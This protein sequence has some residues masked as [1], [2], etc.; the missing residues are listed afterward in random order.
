MAPTSSSSTNQQLR[1]KPP[2]TQL[3]NLLKTQ[4]FYWFLGHVFA[5]LFFIL[6]TLTSFFNPRSSLGYYKFALASIILTYGIVIKQVH[7]KT[8]FT[9]SRRLL[10]DENVQ[11]LL[12]ASI[13][14]IASFK[15]G[16]IHSSLY[17]FEIFAVFHIL[18]YFQNQLLGV[19]ISNIR[20][21]QRLNSI[22]NNFTTKFNQPALFAASNSEIILLLICG[23]NLIPMF[24]L[25]IFRRN[26][27][28]FAIHLFLFGSIVVFNKLRFDSNQYTKVVVEQM[29]AKVNQILLQLNN[30]NLLN[31]YTNVKN[32]AIVYLNK[33][34][35]PKEQIKKN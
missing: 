3:V 24:L 27:I 19:F 16:Q 34:Q 12:L 20:A 4:Q 8:N 11:Y 30:A 25:L 31:L 33:I 21:Q 13:F 22:I 9:I 15:I 18:T 23:F 14:L 32:Q 1:Y 2:L 6:N 10:R 35:I 28:D 29:D 26:F 5:V 7:F 17:S